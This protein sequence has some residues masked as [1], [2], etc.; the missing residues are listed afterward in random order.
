M[1]AEENSKPADLT[2][3]VVFRPNSAASASGIKT[4]AVSSEL[5]NQRNNKLLSFEIEE[6]E[7]EDEFQN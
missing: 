3:R 4:A 1:F 7:E 2:K 5:L 6:E